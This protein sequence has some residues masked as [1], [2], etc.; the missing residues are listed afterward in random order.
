MYRQRKVYPRR[1]KLIS[2]EADVTPQPQARGPPRARQARGVR[3]SSTRTAPT[4]KVYS[5]ASR[6]R[7]SRPSVR[8]SPHRF[9]KAK[10]MIEGPPTFLDKI[11]NG[12]G[13]VANLARAVAPMIEMI[14]TEAKFYDQAATTTFN[15][16]TPYF[17]EF[18]SNISQGSDESNRIGNSVLLKDFQLKLY[19]TRVVDSS[20]A[21]PTL[22][23]FVRI[24]I[25][26]WK[27][28]AQ[29]NPPTVAKIMQG[30]AFS[31]FTNKDYTD[32]FVMLKD[33]TYSLEPPVLSGSATSTAIFR[34]QKVYKKCDWHL[35]WDGGTVNDGTQN[36]I[37][38]MA[39]SSAAQ[40]TSLTWA[41]RINYTDN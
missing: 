21:P 32:Q 26:C 41:S 9:G 36:H 28:N 38:I 37:F 25:F 14:N 24:L 11:A 18:T 29:D 17:V 1:K 13:Q 6:A 15:S 20:T 10:K 30:S 2:R 23:C 34:F 31:S 8:S 3:A 33:K 27:E 22:G 12:V 4:R 39:L 16:A 40:N 7:V 35:R 5:M 19:L